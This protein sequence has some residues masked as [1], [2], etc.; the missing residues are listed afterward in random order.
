MRALPMYAAIAVLL[1]LLLV[2]VGMYCEPPVSVVGLASAAW[3]AWYLWRLR[4][5]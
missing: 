5:A 1:G 4:R 2:S 3:G